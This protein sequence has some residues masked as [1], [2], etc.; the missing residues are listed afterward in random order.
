MMICPHC[1]AAAR[2]VAALEN[3]GFEPRSNDERNAIITA[4]HDSYQAAYADGARSVVASL[5]SILSKQFK[6]VNTLECDE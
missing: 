4:L 6:Y 1:V 5:P 3:L 2:V